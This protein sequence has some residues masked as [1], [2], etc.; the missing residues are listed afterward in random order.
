MNVVW[1]LIMLSVRNEVSFGPEFNTQKACEVAAY[2]I[3]AKIIEQNQWGRINLP[4]C[5]Q[6]QK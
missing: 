5:V 6:I 3:K 2:N 1:L 4:F